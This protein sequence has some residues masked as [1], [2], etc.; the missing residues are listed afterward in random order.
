MK[1][2][3]EYQ[4]AARA[5]STML[6]VMLSLAITL[7]TLLTGLVVTLWLFVPLFYLIR[8]FV[9]NPV[10]DHEVHYP[11]WVPEGL[12]DRVPEL[13]HFP[14]ELFG[15]FFVVITVATGLAIVIVT[16][17]KVVQLW[18]AGGIG[19]A[20]SLGG[21]CVTAEGY[22]CDA[23]TRRAVNVVNEV[24]I[25]ARIPSPH[26]YLLHN[27]PG[28]NAFA[29]GLSDAD[30]VLGLTAGS[31][32]HLNRE[33]LQGIVGHE[34]AHIRN[35]DTVRNIL[36]VGYLHG[37]MGQIV[38][39][40]S[41]LQNGI[42]MLVRS[43]SHGGQ[44]IVGMFVAACGLLLWPVGLI[45]LGCATL[46]KAA[47][48]RQREY[49]ADASALEILRNDR[50]IADAMKRILAHK[51]GSRV[52]SPRCLALSHVFFAKSSCGILGFF[53]SHPPL[54]RRIGRLDKD[55]DGKVQ[56]EDEHQVG[57]FRGVFQGTMSIAQQAR[58]SDCGRIDS[59]ESLDES[60]L[61]I[62]DELAMTVHLHA[63]DV[64]Q[65]LPDSLWS[66]TQ[67]M[68][69]AEAM[70]F[71][72]WAVGTESSLDDDAK[73]CSL[74]KQSMASQTVADALK[75]HL[76]RYELAERLMLFDAAVNTIRQNSEALDLT[77][78]C[79]RADCLLGDQDAGPDVDLFRWSWKKNLKL[80]I[81]RELKRPRPKPEFGDCEELLDDCQVLIS[82]LAQAN[83][84][85]VMRAYSLQ[86]AGN[87]LQHDLELLPAEQ[88]SVAAIDESLERLRR[89]AP[90]ARRRLVLAGSTSIETDS[91]LNAA[92]A[93]LMRGICSGLGYPPATLLPGQ[94][95]KLS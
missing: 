9:P 3:Y 12:L 7:T 63:A 71:A 73:L 24:A 60:P 52:R 59:V 21:I 22:R 77:E 72:L 88:C 83:E 80:I 39:A 53:D 45:G 13:Q 56:Y 5:N 85:D 36:L 74:G 2:F 94:P 70:V 50:G 79:Q 64:R 65:Q 82:A 28:I 30:R 81:D 87:V 38:T 27:E 48:S 51:Q 69:T 89:L 68:A 66:L 20:E 6:M 54:T 47:Y 31:I 18:Q 41:L 23:K 35:G 19:V 62:S 26:V 46:V 49:L 11:D 25:S 76:D 40:E 32:E 1:T 17:N 58:A 57:G 86:R 16:R 10:G 8:Y 55:W 90:Q 4:E 75:P 84:S 78:F 61:K 15:F 34:F 43:I 44:G 67:E 14:W 92:E 29:V 93:L 33:Q 95:V 42:E 91:K 37:L